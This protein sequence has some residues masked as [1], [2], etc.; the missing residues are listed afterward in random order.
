MKF[1]FSAPL[2]A[3]SM[4]AGSN[5][6]AIRQT[7]PSINGCSLY[8][9]ANLNHVITATVADSPQACAQFC[10]NYTGQPTKK[11][12]Y[13]GL[14]R[15]ISATSSLNFCQCYTEGIT[16]T[17]LV[18]QSPPCTTKYTGYE[19]GV[20]DETSAN[21]LETKT[22]YFYTISDVLASS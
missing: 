8:T 6:L 20:F 3:L 5:A 15:H 4:I 16:I 21:T 9:L 2:L 14:F 18:P 17:P 12:V 10:V 11:P 13:I 1:L 7:P 22:I 19:E